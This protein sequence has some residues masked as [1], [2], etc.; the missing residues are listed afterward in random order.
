MLGGEVFF[1]GVLAL[2]QPVHGRVA[3]L[4]DIDGPL[5]AAEAPEGGVGGALGQGELAALIDQAPHDHRQ[6][7]PHP[8]F[9]GPRIEGF[10]QSD[11]FGQAQQG[12]TGPVFERVGGAQGLG[13]GFEHDLPVNRGLD[14][15][16]HVEGQAGEAA[17]GGVAELTGDGIA[18]GGAQDAD[19]G[20]VPALDF[21]VDGV[22]RL[23]G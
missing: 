18:K 1:N 2:Q 20:G 11:V 5:A 8:R 4:V 9:V 19:R 16:Q 21:K 12:G 7:V 17:V 14:E 6:A 23:D 13:V 22:G 15:Q 10:V 3:V